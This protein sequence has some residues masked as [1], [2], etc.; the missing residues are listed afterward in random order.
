MFGN[1]LC[2]ACVGGTRLVDVLDLEV[3]VGGG[4]RVQHASTR[5]LNV[6]L[7]RGDEIEPAHQI[8]GELAGVARRAAELVETERAGGGA[9]QCEEDED[10]R[11]ATPAHEC[12]RPLDH[13]SG[14]SSR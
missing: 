8:V 6:E 14:T 9:E 1:S 5:F 2:D 11:G 7:Q 3:G 13:C 4:E 12:A 10:C